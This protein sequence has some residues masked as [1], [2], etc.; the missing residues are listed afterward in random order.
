MGIYVR[1]NRYTSCNYSRSLSIY[2]KTS[3]VSADC[4]TSTN[5]SRCFRNLDNCL[6]HFHCSVYSSQKLRHLASK[7]LLLTKQH[8]LLN[9]RFYWISSPDFDILPQLPS[10][11]CCAKATY[12]YLSWNNDRQCWRFYRKINQQDE[13]R[14]L[15]FVI[16][17]GEAKTFSVFVTVLTICIL[18]PTV[19]GRILVEFCTD[20]CIQIWYVVFH[21]ELYGINSVVNAFIYGM[22]HVKYRK[23][24][25]HI[26]FT[27][28]SCHKWEVNRCW[29]LSTSYWVPCLQILYLNCFSPCA[30][31]KEQD[32]CTGVHSACR[33]EE[34]GHNLDICVLRR[35]RLRQ[36]QM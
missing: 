11:V 3:E 34:N 30:N 18:T 36:G 19:V 6:L 32:A 21:F 15:I 20:S 7:C 4:D 24:Y 16:L 26:L 27:L 2:C 29:S 25:L 23:A 35:L 28:F 12:V 9:R 10:F 33:R 17:N 14:T 1:F 8:C 22:R 13:L 5:V 31:F